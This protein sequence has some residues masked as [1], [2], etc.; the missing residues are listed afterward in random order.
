MI[1]IQL[2]KWFKKVS[3]YLEQQNCTEILQDPTRIFNADESAFFF[4]PR[5]NKV[6]ALKGDDTVYIY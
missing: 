1:Q 2:R 4:D 5:G 3:E 6:L